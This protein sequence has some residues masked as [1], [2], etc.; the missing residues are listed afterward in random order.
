M[1]SSPRDRAPLPCPRFLLGAVLLAGLGACAD[2][3]AG[4]GGNDGDTDGSDPEV[5]EAARIDAWVFDLG[6]EPM[7]PADLDVRDLAPAAPDGD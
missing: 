4:G 6:T 3:D 2:H 7:P 1:T 5:G